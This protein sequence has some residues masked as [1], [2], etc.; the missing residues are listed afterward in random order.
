MK[1]KNPNSALKIY[2]GACSC[3][4]NYI[5][6]TKINL[7]K[8]WNEHENPRKDSEPVK[9]LREFS[10]NKFNYKIHF[11]APANARLRKI[12]ESPSERT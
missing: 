1:D 12:L 9:H 6:E 7:E 11:T 10:D 3:S 5:F 4:Q 2:G 8:Q